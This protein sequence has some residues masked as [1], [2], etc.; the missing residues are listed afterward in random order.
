MLGILKI[1]WQFFALHLASM[2]LILL[3]FLYSGAFYFVIFIF[4]NNNIDHGK[5][6]SNYIY[7]KIF[8]LKLTMFIILATLIDLG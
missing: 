2:D 4:I 3:I 8:H 5:K 1:Y 6:N 7:S